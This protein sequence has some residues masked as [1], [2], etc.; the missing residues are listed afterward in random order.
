[1]RVLLVKTS[2]MGD[3]IHTLPALTDASI[4]IPSLQVDWLVEEAFVDIPSWHPVVSEVIPVALRRL[5]KNIFAK[6]MRSEWKQWQK[7]LREKQYDLILDAQGLI[8]S[9]IFTLFARGRRAGLNFRSARESLASCVY[10][11]RYVIDRKAHAISRMRSLF[12]QALRYPLPQGEPDFGL[13]RT[14]F[15]KE[16]QAGSVQVE[17]YLVF[18]H[19]TTWSSKQWPEA[20]WIALAEQAR[21]AG[22]RVKISGGNEEEVARAKRIAGIAKNVDVMPR[23]SI[24]EMA[25][26]LAYSKAAVAVDTGFGHLASALSIPTLSI[27][28][29]T[30]PN[31]TG[32]LGKK[33]VHLTAS[34]PCAPCF[35]RI[36]TYKKASVVTPACYEA[37]TSERVW[38]RLKIILLKDNDRRY[39]LND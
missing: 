21:K 4:A 38:E 17:P 9:A 14:Q 16:T 25:V 36:C 23:L 29:S 1:M 24:Q 37:I 26:L 7:K 28:G 6:A 8:K 22:F 19:G 15:Q 3:L 5:R 30:D 11:D 33:S 32:A 31:Y 20:Y 12:S 2:S 27:Y 10:Q 13:H 39:L 34:F 35:S 18:L